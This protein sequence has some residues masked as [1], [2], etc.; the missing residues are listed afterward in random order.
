MY[1]STLLWRGRKVKIEPGNLCSIRTNIPTMK[2]LCKSCR[3]PISPQD[4]NLEMA[5]AKCVACGEVFSFLEQMGGEI[6]AEPTGRLPAPK[7]QRF[8]VEEFGS[9][10]TISYRWFTP[11]LFVMVF[12]CLFWD[13]FMVMWYSIAIGMIVNGQPAAWAMAAFGLL[14]LAVGVGI[15]Y[16]TF[17]SFVNSTQIKISGG[18]LTIRHGPVRWGGNQTLNV[19]DILQIYCSDRTHSSRRR[20]WQSYQL[21]V[22]KKDGG[23]LVLLRNLNE[24]EE[25]L[26]LEEQLEQKLGIAPQK[27]PGELRS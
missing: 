6:R 4:I 27:V 23:K 16:S 3:L 25:A 19:D 11:A 9:E 2:L 10:L 12:F 14:H 24:P 1:I 17:A 5:I 22:L 21:N 20:Q 26:F 15:T 8:A 13:G 18:E 7:P